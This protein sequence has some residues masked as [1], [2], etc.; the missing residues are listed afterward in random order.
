MTEKFSI[1]CE[2]LD[3]IIFEILAFH[4]LEPQAEKV[5]KV[6]AKPF[7]QINVR[8][9]DPT[10]IKTRA[11]STIMDRKFV[12][13]TSLGSNLTKNDLSKGVKKAM[14]LLKN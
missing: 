6:T 3:E 2:V 14:L 10:K 12:S 1:A 8:D 5:V 7:H 9:R 4:I 13:H 11:L